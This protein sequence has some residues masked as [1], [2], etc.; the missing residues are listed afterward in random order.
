MVLIAFYFVALPAAYF[1]T[2]SLTMGVVGLWWGVVAGSIAEILL[3]VIILRFFCDWKDL[4]FTIS[5]QLRMT[6][7]FSPN[8][9]MSRLSRHSSSHK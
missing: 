5:A 2:F 8:A 1:F 7:V 3:Y 4:A 9:S 6:G